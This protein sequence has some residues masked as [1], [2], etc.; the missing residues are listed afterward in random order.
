[1]RHLFGRN[2]S[3][4]LSFR[5]WWCR[6]I[7]FEN[8]FHCPSRKPDQHATFQVPQSDSTENWWFGSRKARIPHLQL[9]G[10]SSPLLTR[11]EDHPSNLWMT[12]YHLSE[13]ECTYLVLKNVKWWLLAVGILA[14]QLATAKL[15]LYDH[16]YNA[17]Y[18]T[19]VYA[20]IQIV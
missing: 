7:I 6:I 8:H 5:K 12:R 1:M 19:N 14:L 17:K 9:R 10:K 16:D 4:Q 20:R 2:V 13:S 18:Q 15:K 3:L 11:E